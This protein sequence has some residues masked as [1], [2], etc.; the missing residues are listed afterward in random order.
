MQA[1]FSHLSIRLLAP[2]PFI[3]FFPASAQSLSTYSNDFLS[4][5]FNVETLWEPA[6]SAAWSAYVTR[7]AGFGTGA[8]GY[9]RHY[10]VAVA[11]NVNGKFMRDFAFAAAA[12][13]RDNYIPLGKGTFWK[14]VWNAVDYT[15]LTSP[16]TQDH[17]FNWSGI[18]ASFA[19]AGLS[20]VYQP[21]QQRTWLATIERAGTNTAGYIAGNLWLEFTKNKMVNHPRIQRI[22]KSR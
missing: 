1:L 7:P 2:I 14:R 5:T 9:A 16:E 20:N 13:R 6:A 4:S 12:G 15:V 19:S 17:T 10:G 21:P 22:L 18:P 3:A 11:D 8:D